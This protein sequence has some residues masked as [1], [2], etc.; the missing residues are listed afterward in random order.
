MLTSRA[1]FLAASAAFAAATTACG[2]DCF[3][4]GTMV[5]TPKGDRRIEDLVVGDEVLA[6]DGGAVVVRTVLA[7]HERQAD[8]VF[9]VRAGDV[10]IGGVSAEHPVWDDSVQAWRP[11]RSLTLASRLLVLVQGHL[12]VQNVV[13][14]RRAAGV[15]TVFN[16]SVSA[17][18]NNYFVEGVLVHNKTETCTVDADCGEASQYICDVGPTEPGEPT[19][20]GICVAVDC[21]EDDDCDDDDVCNDDFVCEAPST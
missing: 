15:S 21:K 16:L 13:E 4:R 18:E 14:L 10:V 9:S 8:E 1:A 5:K 12:A 17:P 11:V 6:Y 7:C 20:D 3:V 2:G 19:P